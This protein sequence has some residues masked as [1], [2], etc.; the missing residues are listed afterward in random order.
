[1]K[2]LRRVRDAF[3]AV[4]APQPDAEK[5][6]GARRGQSC[7]VGTESGGLVVDEHQAGV[8]HGYVRAGRSLRTGDL[9]AVG[10]RLSVEA[11]RLGFSRLVIQLGVDYN[12]VISRIAGR[13]QHPRCSALD[14]LAATPP[15]RAREL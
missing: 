1:M 8:I 2:G 14:D 3:E 13:R 12:K 4:A 7:L 6:M 15:E 9:R 5:K 11:P 10:R